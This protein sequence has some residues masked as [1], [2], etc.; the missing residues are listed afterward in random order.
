LAPLDQPDDLILKA[1]Y[2]DFL[3]K[4]NLD[5]TR[6]QADLQVTAPGK[7]WILEAQIEAH[8]Y[9][10]S[11]RQMEQA[12]FQDAAV[13][14][15][16]GVYQGVAQGIGD[17]GLLQDFPN[18]TETDLYLWIF[19]HRAELKQNLAWDIAPHELLANLA[20]QHR[21]RTLT[22]KSLTGKGEAPAVRRPRTLTGQW[23]R[24]KMVMPEQSRLFFNILVAITGQAEGW[25]ALEQ[26]FEIAR[27]E[28]GKILG[29]HLVSST[30]DLDGP[31][32][33]TLDEEFN[34]RCQAANIAG[35]LTIEAGPAVDMICH[36]AGLADL[37]VA[38][39]LNPPGSR[40]LGR[41]SSEFRT[42]IQRCARPVLA[43][44]EKPSYF[45]RLLLA[46]DGNSKAKEALY[47][48]AYLTGRW[49][50]PLVVLTVTEENS[51]QNAL[52]T[53]AKNYLEQRN[54]PALFVEQTGAAAEK[55][56]ETAEDHEADLIIMGGYGHSKLKDLVLGSSVD[57][58]LRESDRAMLICR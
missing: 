30:G 38:P 21:P 54:V 42:L 49:R 58:V 41:I 4:S 39:L 43:V 37:V 55:I 35:S 34:R 11:G 13:F 14:W 17:R 56:L 29:L 19:E 36:R 26:A 57:Q 47:V 44:P 3:E 32:A 31:I 1:E 9:L 16:D 48:A 24:E 45:T 53:E 2:A 22:L 6:P 51:N 50:V 18:R 23:R 27:R 28:H 52:Q 15:Y 7:Y 25:Q 33:R 5:V 46:Y 40:L 10:V 8:R 12:S 20:V